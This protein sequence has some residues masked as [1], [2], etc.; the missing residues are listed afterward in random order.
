M[1]LISGAC[2]QTRIPKLEQPAAVKVGWTVGSLT[3]AGIYVAM[4]KGYFRDANLNVELVGVDNINALI[5]PI[6]TGQID[7][8]TGGPSAGFFNALGRG[9]KLRIVADQNT[10]RPGMSSIA[11]MVRKDLID[12]GQVKTYSDLKGRTIAVVS[13]RA[14]M[15][16]DVLKALEKGGL[17]KSDV[18]LINLGFP[19]MNMAFGSNSIDAALQIEPLVSDAVTRNLAVRWKGVDEITPNRQN[20]FFIVSENFFA[21]KDVARAFMVAYLRGVRDYYDGIHKKKGNR[22]EIISILTRH[23]LIKDPAV[24]D[25]VV[26][27][28]ID[29][30]GELNVPSIQEALNQ[31]VADGDV[32]SKIDLNAVVDVSY[33]RYAQDVLGRYQP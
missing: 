21:K 29:P 32:K 12:S 6:A 26:L 7:V 31:F 2:A 13:R 5:G 10:A 17:T 23:T 20:S 27:P 3:L 33:I 1:T 14:T 16:L 25:R 24:Y 11:L 22:G 15:E 28:A 19:Q 8:A 9:V 30:N 18:N 4:D